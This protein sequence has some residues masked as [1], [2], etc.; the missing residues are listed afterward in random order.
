M[1]TAQP[2]DVRGVIATELSDSDIQNYLDD[3]EFEAEQAI[4]DYQ[5]ALSNTEQTQLEK[6]VAALRIREWADRAVESTSRETASMS[7][8]GMSI[9][10]LKKAVDKRDPSGTLAFQTDTDRYTG[11]SEYE[12]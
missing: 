10:A 6:Y 2:S 9:E 4:D 3:A 8:E 1:S 7:F 11:V 12:S 5:N